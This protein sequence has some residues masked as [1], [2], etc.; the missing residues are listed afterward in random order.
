M[1]AKKQLFTTEEKPRTQCAADLACRFAG[2]L[3]VRTLP[4]DQ[5]ICVDHY[6]IAIQRDR[7][8]I[9]DTVPPKMSGVVAKPV[10]GS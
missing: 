9:G 7:S 3:W 10:S 1:A 6:C 4:P 8:L 5:R 2:M